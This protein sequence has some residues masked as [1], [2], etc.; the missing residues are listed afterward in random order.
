MSRVFRVFRLN[1]QKSLTTWKTFLK[2][3]LK[4][5]KCFQLDIVMFGCNQGHHKIIQTR[6]LVGVQGNW[7]D[8]YTEQEIQ[9][10]T[11]PAQT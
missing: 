2:V 6:T 10:S 1:T 5:L 9:A 7:I 4:E 8:V 3:S 11:A